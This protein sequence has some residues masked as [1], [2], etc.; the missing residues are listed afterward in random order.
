MNNDPKIHREF[1][2]QFIAGKAEGPAN[3]EA[4]PAVYKITND[5]R[6]TPVGKFLRKDES[7]RVSAVLERIAR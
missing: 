2:Q 7:G 6:M 4:E 3:S 5:P 1:V